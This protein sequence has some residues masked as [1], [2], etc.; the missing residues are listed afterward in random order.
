MKNRILLVLWLA[1]LLSPFVSVGQGRSLQ[2]ANKT[3]FTKLTAQNNLVWEAR[4]DIRNITTANSFVSVREVEK[5][6]AY[7]HKVS[8]CW[9]GTCADGE[10]TKS[11]LP[12]NIN[13][14]ES[15]SS[16]RVYVKTNGVEGQSTM[17]YRFFTLNNTD[18]VDV[19]FV[20]NNKTKTVA[21][22]NVTGGG[23]TIAKEVAISGTIDAFPNP[24][25]Q[26]TSIEY[27]LSQSFQNAYV[28]V[29]DLMG[30]E[31]AQYDL[32][33]ENGIIRLNLRNYTEGIY[34]YTLVADGKSVAT[35]KL[36]VSK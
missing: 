2:V 34:F 35:K 31:M 23:T 30:K 7:G 9:G 17:T 24:A 3:N 28:K 22:V 11:V 5:N 33:S 21:P 26:Q 4:A 10:A 6:T 25:S 16:F 14:K 19:Q 8:F 18:S 12:L 29:Y 20:F 27:S 1:M 32:D 13:A 15:N 36:V